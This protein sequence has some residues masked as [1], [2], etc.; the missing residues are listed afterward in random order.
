MHVYTTDLYMYIQLQARCVYNCERPL[1]TN[2]DTHI[3]TLNKAEGVALY[4][5]IRRALRANIEDGILEPGA[6]LPSEDELAATFGVS[7]MTVRKGIADLL[8]EGILYRK[9]G[10]GTF[11]SQLQIERDHNRLTP[12]F[13]SAALDRYDAR[14]VVLE[15]EVRPAKLAVAKALNLK[16]GEPAVYIR[17]LR[18]ADGLPITLHDEFVPYKLCPDLLYEDLTTKLTWEAV[19]GFGFPVK[20]AVQKIEAVSVDEEIANLLEMREGDSALYKQRTVFAVDG[21]PVEFA[22]CYNRGDRYSLTMT[23]SR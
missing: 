21:T 20:Y 9:R 1:D 13:D 5:Q 19:E 4:V 18:M 6:Q 16:E 12:F 17:T 11:V 2:I 7:R 23:L 10:V 3:S 22:L 15:Q 8:D 14:I